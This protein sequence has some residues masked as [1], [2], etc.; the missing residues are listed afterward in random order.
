MPR[1][2]EE[3]DWIISQLES[4]IVDNPGHTFELPE[5]LRDETNARRREHEIVVAF[6]SRA[7]LQA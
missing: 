5:N 3:F 2:G 6:P 7:K 1:R 4:T